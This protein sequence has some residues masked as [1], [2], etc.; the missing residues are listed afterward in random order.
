[1]SP[2]LADYMFQMMPVSLNE[3]ASNKTTK[4]ALPYSAL[5]Y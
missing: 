3:N 5:I 1:V 2:L 4:A